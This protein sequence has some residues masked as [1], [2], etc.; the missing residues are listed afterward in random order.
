MSVHKEEI[1]FEWEAKK[2]DTI[3]IHHV[4]GMI[5]EFSLSKAK[6]QNSSWLY[7]RNIRALSVASI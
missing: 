3:F 5:L 4:I 2:D 1:T 6:F 7:S